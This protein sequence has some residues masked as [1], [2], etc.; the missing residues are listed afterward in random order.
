MNWLFFSTQLSS[1]ALLKSIGLKRDS[2]HGW[3]CQKFAKSRC[4]PTFSQR[5]NEFL[6][7][8]KVNW[9]EKRPNL[10]MEISKISKVTLSP[11]V[12]HNKTKPQETFHCVLECL[13]LRFISVQ[14]F[15]LTMM[16]KECKNLHRFLLAAKLVFFFIISV[17]N[18]WLFATMHHWSLV[19]SKSAWIIASKRINQRP[20]AEKSLGTCV[21]Q[22]SFNK[23]QHFINITFLSKKN[24]L[25]FAVYFRQDCI[26][27]SC[28]KKGYQSLDRDKKSMQHQTCSLSS[29]S[30]IFSRSLDAHCTESIKT[31][32]TRSCKDTYVGSN[33]YQPPKYGFCMW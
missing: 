16:C 10:L 8:I 4:R 13:L 29:F 6:C 30:D 21:T 7:L 3:K 15:P 23:W 22:K 12:F 24:K 32:Q 33:F 27:Q 17:I 5:A 2:I 1:Y 14:W 28:A 26:R 11:Y 25:D 19:V 9:I 18:V 31:F 20:L